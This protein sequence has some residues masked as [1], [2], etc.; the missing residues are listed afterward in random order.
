MAKDIL[1]VGVKLASAQCHYEGFQSKISLLDW[2]IILFSPDLPESFYSDTSEY[3]GKATFNDHYSFKLKECTEHW[4]REIKQAVEA[5]KTVVVFLSPLEEVFVATGSNSYSGSGKNR[6]VTRLVDLH[7]NYQALPIKLSPVNVTGK[8]MKV[9]NDPQGIIAPYWAAFGDLSEY[10]VILE[11]CDGVVCIATK[12]G[13]KP[14]G[15]IARTKLSTGALILLPDIDFVPNHFIEDVKGANGRFKKEWSKAAIQFAGQMVSAVVE[16][17]KAIHSSSEVTPEPTWASGK[18]YE[19]R[20]ERVLR[21]DLLA[22]EQRV[23]E[24][25]KHK[26]FVQDE[27]KSAG[28]LRGLTY[29]KGPA[30]ER[31]IIIALKLMGFEAEPYKDSSSEFDVVFTCPEGRLLGEAEGKDAKPI[32]IEKLRQ[33]SMNIHEDLQREEVT[34]PAKP[35]LFGNGFRLT[36]LIERPVQFTDKCIS[37]AKTSSTAL[38]STSSLFEVSRYLSESEDKAFATACRLS[39]LRSTGEV[40]WPELPDVCDQFVSAEEKLSVSESP[41]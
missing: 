29:E 14:V 32:N 20:R 17:D 1:T 37:A 38:V 28:A 30:L 5:G 40:G 39:L 36:P 31:A 6:S 26:E 9:V 33:L 19:L 21:A 25:Q 27:L 10:K 7:N 22:A 34:E 8:N 41:G 35:V 18:S 16:L 12:T 23:E 3:L 2:D 13:D 11:K 4:R 15:A 24:A